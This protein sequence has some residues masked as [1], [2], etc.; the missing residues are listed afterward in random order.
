MK[1]SSVQLFL[2]KY[3]FTCQVMPHNIFTKGESILDIILQVQ[4]NN[5]VVPRK[6]KVPLVRARSAIY[7]ILN[8]NCNGEFFPMAL[9]QKNRESKKC[10]FNLIPHLVTRP[11]SFRSF[12][13]N[14]FE[15][16][17]KYVLSYDKVVVKGSGYIVLSR[18]HSTIQNIL[19]EIVRWYYHKQKPFYSLIHVPR[20]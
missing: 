14:N 11:G 4:I 6:I 18:G 1:P 13:R 10:S 2:F 16:S 19:N 7:R 17:P 8:G 3:S 15:R 12:C 20:Y 9:S 5:D